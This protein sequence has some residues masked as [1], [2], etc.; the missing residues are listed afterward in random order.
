MYSAW[1][2][3]MSVVAAFML[4]FQ[5]IRTVV[6]YIFSTILTV[7]IIT[8]TIWSENDEEGEA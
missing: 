5:A 3:V 6:D 7:P 2:S 4:C 8:N 1:Q